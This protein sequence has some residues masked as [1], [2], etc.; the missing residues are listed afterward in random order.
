[1]KIVIGVVVFCLIVNSVLS[2]RQPV[3]S[4]NKWRRR[5]G[6]KTGNVK[7][8]CAVLAKRSSC[9]FYS[10]CV[11]KG[12]TSC[13]LRDAAEDFCQTTGAGERELDNLGK[14]YLRDVRTCIQKN[15]LGLSDATSC[16]STDLGRVFAQS[17]IKSDCIYQNVSLCAVL[18]SSTNVITL[19]DIFSNLESGVFTRQFIA[20]FQ[21]LSQG[22]NERS[23][24]NIENTFPREFLDI[25]RPGPDA[26]S[27][28]DTTTSPTTATSATKETSTSIEL[29]GRDCEVLSKRTSC[30]FYPACVKPDEAACALREDTGDFCQQATAAEE[31]FDSL[32]RKYLQDV[33]VCLQK[34]LLTFDNVTSCKGNQLGDLE[35]VF[36]PSGI[37]SDCLYQNVSLCAV[38]NT[39]SN[40]QALF[41][42][43]ASLQSGPFQQQFISRFDAL[44]EGCN[45]GAK[46]KFDNIF[47]EDATEVLTQV[48]DTVRALREC[49]RLAESGDCEF[50]TQCVSV[51]VN[52]CYA[53]DESK[54]FCEQTESKQDQLDAKGLTYIENVRKC[55]MKNQLQLGDFIP[56]DTLNP[57]IFMAIIQP[58]GR[59]SDCLLQSGAVCTV[60]GNR[61]NAQ[62]I[63][64]M[65]SSDGAG[66]VQKRIAAYM[67]LLV[68]QVCGSGAQW[69]VDTLLPKTSPAPALTGCDAFSVNASCDFFPSCLTAATSDCRIAT[70][71]HQ[72]CINS[73]DKQAEFDSM[74]VTYIE[75]V[76]RC[77]IKKLLPLEG[78]RDCK[79]VDTSALETLTKVPGCLWQKGEFCKL[80]STET[81]CIAL[82]HIFGLGGP[83]LDIKYKLFF[84]FNNLASQCSADEKATFAAFFSK[85]FL[86]S[87]QN[88]IAATTTT[89]TTSTTTTTTTT[90]SSTRMM[91]SGFNG[92]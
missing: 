25:L 68:Q 84:T 21:S 32:G 2:T 61:D 34:N 53:R 43:F 48:D 24:E 8:N 33:R 77:Q 1:M 59:S 90:P 46:E 86:N 12:V 22:C 14:R 89:V 85:K 49:E 62:A 7:T 28:P 38:V 72:Y 63:R 50:Y 20:R 65:F 5:G 39:I 37:K 42:L 44:V 76:R 16:D 79:D 55:L 23:K 58:N 70:Q 56:C 35:Q 75:N 73:E 47:P 92:D 57:Q 66:E 88:D 4:R 9:D 45:E 60:L 29:R 91:M 52:T 41:D 87:V 78:S 13:S 18:S 67:V 30:D 40:V 36:A 6:N 11:K 26:T 64:N 74:G 10:A 83:N 54:G 31:Q 17:D 82:F 71:V 19:L 27:T 15:L 80:V 51:G 81:N 3:T 69:I